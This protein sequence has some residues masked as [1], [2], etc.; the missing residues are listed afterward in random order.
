MKRIFS[1]LCVSVVVV[2]ELGPRSIWTRG[3]PDIK[4]R[5]KSPFII[6]IIIT[7]MDGCSARAVLRFLRSSDHGAA[8]EPENR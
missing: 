8:F 3:D 6:I 5:K 1:F 2:V 7:I 4:K